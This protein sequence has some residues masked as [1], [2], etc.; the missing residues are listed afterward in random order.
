MKM[1]RLPVA[2]AVAALAGIED[3]SI[4]VLC[5]KG[6]NGGD[7]AATARLL[8]VAGGEVDVVLSAR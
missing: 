8:V 4:L 1:P 2:R 6:N 3:Q 7:G 5:G